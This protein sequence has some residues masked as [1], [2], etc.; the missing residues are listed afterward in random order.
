M[1]DTDSCLFAINYYRMLCVGYNQQ[2]C[3]SEA[4]IGEGEAD[5]EIIAGD[6]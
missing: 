2:P 3:Y 5:N 1:N 4:T 6:C